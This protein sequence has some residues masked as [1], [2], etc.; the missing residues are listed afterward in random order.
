MQ[1]S[2]LTG[3]DFPMIDNAL[4]NR[5]CQARR[6]IWRRALGA[7]RQP[8]ATSQAPPATGRGRHQTKP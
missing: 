5:F 8:T 7:G 3:D 2:G 4:I 6:Y 1:I